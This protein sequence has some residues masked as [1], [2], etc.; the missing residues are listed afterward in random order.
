M[1]GTLDMMGRGTPGLHLLLAPVLFLSGTL[2]GLGHAVVLGIASRCDGETRV[3]VLRRELCAVAVSLPLLGLGWLVASAITVG[4]AVDGDSRVGFL[5]V[6]VIGWVL[7]LTFCVWAAREGWGALRHA[8]RRC[9][10]R[11]VGLVTSLA[12]ASVTS[13]VLAEFGSEI[14]GLSRDLAW[15]RAIPIGVL[16]TVWLWIPV[17]YIL[18][19]SLG[20]SAPSFPDGAWNG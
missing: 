16:L 10:R 3:D 6:A 2:L 14:P 19:N 4:V 18:L 11:S 13:F 12:S 9:P 20:R 7:G 15:R 1:I 17:V 8:Y 5:V